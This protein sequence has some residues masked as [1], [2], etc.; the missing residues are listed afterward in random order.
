MEVITLG[1]PICKKIKQIYF[2]NES[3]QKCY[4][5]V[6]RKFTTLKKIMRNI[7]TEM[8][9]LD[10]LRKLYQFDTLDFEDAFELEDKFIVNVK[11]DDKIKYD[12]SVT[13]LPV[14]IE[15]IHL[16]AEFKKMLS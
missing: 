11:K 9:D 12:K 8:S 13:W 10:I 2:Q 4:K 15:K 6:G 7:Y 5:D 14:P 1:E 16:M 3:W